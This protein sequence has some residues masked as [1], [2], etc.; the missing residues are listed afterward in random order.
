[1]YPQS[2]NHFS[3]T[4][5]PL[6]QLPTNF[7]PFDYQ[8]T[9]QPPPQ[10]PTNFDPYEP[11]YTQQKRRERVSEQLPIRDD[12]DDDEYFDNVD[13]ILETQPIDKEAEQ[14]EEVEEVPRPKS[15]KKPSKIWTPDEEEALAKS[16]IKISV[17]KEVGDRQT[18]LG[19]W[20]RVLKHFRTLVLRT[21]RTHH[22][23]N[24]KW[25]P[26]H[27][28]IAAFNSYYIQAAAESTG[29]SKKRKSSE[30]SSAQTPTNET[31]INVEDF[32]YDLP[33]LNENPTPSRQPRGKKKWILEIQA[34]VRCVIPLQVTRPKRKV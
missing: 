21:E 28:M 33:N 9:Q 10:M 25:T 32:D 4:Q 15:G 27:Q 29:S 11:H 18:K 5:Q 13:M 2:R 30:S 17:D 24:S 14:V 3:T 23:L 8:Y 22:Q 1:M 16:W 31:P 19:F 6:P 20:K 7:E 26:M 12:T 34:E